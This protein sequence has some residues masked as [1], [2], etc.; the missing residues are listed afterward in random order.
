MRDTPALRRAAPP[1]VVIGAGMGGL[2][3][4]LR[5]AHA[6]ARVTVVDRHATPGGKMR[7][8]PSAAGPVDAGPTVLTMR[9]VFDA[10][11]SDVGA[12]TSDHV[13][14][15]PEPLLARHFW[16]DGGRLDLWDNREANRAAIAGF[17]GARAAAEFDAFSDR[18]ERL[19]AGFEGPV[20]AA[21]RLDAAALT[22]RVLRDPGLL[23]AMAPGRSLRAL[24]RATF[25]D[26]R[27]AQLFG[28]YATYVGGMPGQVPA[29]LALI[30]QAEAGGVW[31]VRG[32]MHALARA[33]ADLAQANG[34]GFI[35]GTGAAGIETR[36]GRVAA[37]VLDDGRRLP[38]AAVLFAGDPRA[39][40][41]GLLG[42]RAAGAVARRGVEPRSL[43]AWVWSFA[44]APQGVDLAHHNVFFAA[45]P[46]SEFA[47]L[48]AGRMPDA[49]TLYI[50]A[51]DRGSD[52]P[53]PSGPERFE[54]IQNAPPRDAAPMD[55]TE[56]RDACHRKC[57]PTLARFGLTFGPR[58]G[59]DSAVLTTPAGFAALVPGSAGSLYGRSPAGPL[60]SF[61]RPTARSRLPGLYLAGGG[62]HPGAGVPMVAISGR[63][64]AAAI[65]TDLALTSTCPPTAMPGGTS[66]A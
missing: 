28:R 31:R 25:S 12:A 49:P 5:L 34:A 17:A 40:H 35:L 2:S 1:V 66:T 52:A 21:P 53:A 47:D 10:L 56:E 60:A 29:L 59:T 14:L 58:P 36:A 48:A 42:P 37:V 9:A 7:R 45:D 64:A 65:A 13:T 4:A 24:L 63:H 3:A 57:F 43:S 46:D 27:L 16:P 38:A 55:E 22:A 39:L 62:A 41:R 8:L 20:M 32:G 23:R 33:I 61:L 51:Q 50:C 30:W 11:F 15:I 44:A 18:A 19:F 26:R 54:I 6:G